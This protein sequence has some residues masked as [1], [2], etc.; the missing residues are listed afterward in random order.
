MDVSIVVIAYNYAAYIEQCIN[1]CLDQEDSCVEYEVIVVDDGSTDNTPIILDKVVHPRLRKYRVE[2]CGIEK[3]SNFGFRKAS[4]NYIVR[5]DADDTLCLN[6]FRKIQSYLNEEYAFYYPDYFVIDADGKVIEKMTLPEFRAIEVYHRGDFLATGTLY[7]AK[8]LLEIGG[9]STSIKN[10]GL[11]NYELILR[12]IK[13]G[14]NGKH[15]PSCL[16]S[17]RRHSLNISV[18]RK[19]QV[20]RNGEKLFL[21]MGLGSFTTN[22][23][24]PYKL[25]VEKQ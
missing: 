24:H 10:C 18:L 21:R 20:V 14:F 17:Y 12:L 2:N 25:I 7:S 13:S 9:Y 5:V 8:I 22:K 3:A 4:G 11:E 23:Y 1:S 6:Y 19:D 15:I 16:F